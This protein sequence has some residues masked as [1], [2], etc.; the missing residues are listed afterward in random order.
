MNK[1]NKNISFLNIYA[2]ILVCI[3]HSF[4]AV[5][6]VYWHKWI[7]A[8]HM[9]LFMFLSGF[10]LK[11]STQ[12]AGMN[13]YD[14]KLLGKYGYIAKRAKRLLLP[15]FV[16]SSISF[17]P[18]YFLSAHA[19][20]PIELSFSSYMH[21]LLYP[22]DNVI[23]FFWFLPTLFIIGIITVILY[24]ITHKLELNLPLY[25]PMCILFF[26][27]EHNIAEEVGFLNIAGIFSYLVYFILGCWFPKYE[28]AIRN[29][30]RL[31]KPIVFICLISLYSLLIY[32][33][34]W[35][36][37]YINIIYSTIGILFS[38]SLSILYVK[39]GF[40]FLNHL[41]GATYSIYLFSWYP[42]VLSQSF[43]MKKIILPWEIWAIICT[44]TQIY[45]PYI[46]WKGILYIKKTY[47]YGNIIASLLGQ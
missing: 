3:G 37:P 12:K 13:I 33:T 22:W 43:L 9:P 23:K 30:C 21:M 28:Y 18:K 32:Y 24:K 2:I 4:T 34:S 25:I 17:L 15:Y 7:Y 36:T 38:Y 41:R 16:I 1:T 39:C 14:I 27:R 31:S 19:L 20:R 40:R 46:L 26:L 44:I 5:E 29:K 47:R 11:Y 45:I 6:S 42:L 8:Y 35:D 10:L